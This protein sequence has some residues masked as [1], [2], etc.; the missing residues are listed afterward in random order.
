MRE[1][2][3]TPRPRR[4]AQKPLE[5]RSFKDGQ[6]YLFRRADYKKPT[7]F[8][9]IKVPNTK[10]YISCSTKTTDEHQA[11]AFANDVFNKALVKVASGQDLNSKRVSVAIEEYTKG[12]SAQ[13][14]MKLSTLAQVQFLQRS[15]PFF[16]TTRLK[17]INTA[18]LSE[19]WDW[20]SNISRGG[21][22]S[23]NTTKRYSV[24]LKQ[25]FD[26]CLERGFIDALPRFP[27][28][29]TDN[30]RRPAFDNKDY[31]KLTRN[32]REFI[33]VKDKNVARDRTLLINYVLILAN[34]GIRVGEARQLRWRDIEK[35]RSLKAATNQR[36]LRC[37]SPARQGH[38]RSSQD[39][40]M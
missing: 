16:G 34:T 7:W 39:H 31:A 36:T 3:G 1:P 30:A 32:L 38:A 13:P 25:F 20:T 5:S 8:C 24:N 40:L 12:L 23:P 22:L 14:R 21:Q 6:I 15:I 26:W 4:T 27:R 28:I 19:F 29:K 10:G 17:D 9:R 18:K 37:S 33:K 35:S 2:K 11:F